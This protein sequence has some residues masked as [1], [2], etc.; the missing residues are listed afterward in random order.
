MN[1]RLSSLA[2]LATS[3]VLLALVPAAEAQVRVSPNYRLNSDSAPFR[4][5]DQSA[6]AVNR[7]NAQHVVQVNAN[8]LDLICEASVSRDGGT[9]WSAATPLPFP[10]PSGGQAA[11]IPSCQGFQSVEFGSGQNVYFTATA[12][13]TAPDFPDSATLVWKSTDGGASWGPGVV[14]M[15]AGPGRTATTDPNPGPSYFR[16]SLSVEPGAAGGADRVYVVAQTGSLSRSTVSNDGG[17][18]YGAVSTINPAGT[19]STDAP[20]K[21]V[22][23]DDGSVTVA[24]RT[25]GITG[26]IKA[27]RSTDQGQ[28]WG[29]PV[30]ITGVVN[31]GTPTT[32]HIPTNPP[33]GQSTSASYPR[34]VAG[35]NGTLYLVFNQG[36]GGPNPPPGGYQGADHFISPDSQVYFT[37]STN[38]GAT[39]S[40][41]KLISGKTTFPGALTHQTRH[42]SVSFA[43]NRINIVWH[44]RRHWYGGP[45]ERNCSHSHAYCQDI[46]LADTYLSTSTNGGSTFSA[47]RRVSDRSNNDDVGYDTRPSAYWN[48]GPQS[49]TVGGGQ[50]LVGWMDSREG[51]W[52]NENEDTYLAKVNFSGSGSA[53]RTSFAQ[54][55]PVARSVALARHGYQGGNEGGL[56]GTII[57]PLAPAGCTLAGTTACPSGPASRKVSSVVIVNQGHVA[58]ALAGAV[59]ARANPAPVL[60][61]PALGLP[62]SVKAEVTRMRPAGA[63]VIG[64]TSKL[65]NQVVTDL[66]GAGVPAGA[67][68]RLGA[69][70]D[71]ATAALIAAEMDKRSALNKDTA[72]PAF[73]AAIIANP[74]SPD[75]AAAAGLA[76]ARRLPFLYVG[77]DSVPA[78]TLS[79]LGSLDIEKALIIG[80]PNSVSENVRAQ[81]GNAIGSVGNATRLGGANQYATS[82][83]V[84]TESKARGLPDN[85]VYFADGAKPMDGALLGNV[86]GRVTALLALTP[87]SVAGTA[88]AQAAAFGLNDLDRTFLA[89]PAA[90]APPKAAP[91]RTYPGPGPAGSIAAFRGCP[92]LTANVIRGSAATN[93]I[94]G[95][96]RGDRIFALGG[97]DV[98]S[99]LAGNDCVD[100]GAGT[101]RATGASG[102][103]LILGGAG[104]DRVSG[105]SGK[106]KING[107]SAADN[108]KGGSGNDSLTG[109]SGGDKIN[110][111][112]GKDKIS[113]G[114][115]NDRIS[116]R[117]RKRDR[118]SCGAGRRDRATVDRVDRVSRNCER[119][120]RSRR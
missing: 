77:A 7:S 62:A 23:N 43:N 108:L 63:F 87:G 118:V 3:V 42:P 1:F 79:A 9:T 104:K 113:G 84:V 50:L 75:A 51:N 112:S 37:R 99:A 91:K 114:G 5:H 64:D 76:A 68:K 46:R 88:A 34:M 101:D 44:D 33:S 45:G 81:V 107:G 26:L 105:G 36:S 90:T 110:G 78:E 29:T 98:V 85:V 95:T 53:A 19:L 15:A 8:Y 73:D 115:G 21:P 58:G 89:V 74:A 38:R 6:L 40:E 52:D 31:T 94:R 28:T 96:A 70:S 66:V 120:R 4:G 10:A 116:A 103:D 12:A 27:S 17:Q 69:A 30:D 60:L 106:D 80:G 71:S 86:A 16:P 57:D 111:G 93:T 100:L 109:G 55:D 54:T 25:Q 32:T 13:R 117:D 47:P 18:T 65:S 92:N 20:S 35:P 56:V 83:A 11:F 2:V 41:P 14:A 82:Q 61:S 102:N 72:A 119:V 59:L 48:Y 67:I 97:N 24:W 39:W 49:V 22:I